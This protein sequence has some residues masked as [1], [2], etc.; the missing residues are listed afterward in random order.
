MKDWDTSLL[1]QV[2]LIFFNKTDFVQ[3]LFY[4]NAL[5]TVR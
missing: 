2:V 5:V 4:E 1:P 3:Y